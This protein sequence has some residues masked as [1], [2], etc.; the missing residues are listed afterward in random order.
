MVINGVKG[1][2]KVGQE[3]GI[4]KT[5]YYLCRYHNYKWIRQMNA[6]FEVLTVVVMNSFIFWGVMPCSLVSQLRFQGTISPP[7]SGLRSSSC[8]F[9][10]WLS[11]HPWRWKQQVPPKC[12]LTFTGLHGVTSHKT[13][14][15]QMKNLQK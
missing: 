7:S 6:G 8:W 10:A 9:L 11:F 2:I 14:L 1:R 4:P 13:E 5:I 15:F 3:S 12:Q